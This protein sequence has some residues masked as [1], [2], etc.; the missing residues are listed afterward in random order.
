MHANQLESH[1]IPIERSL[2]GKVKGSYQQYI[3]FVA[4]KCKEKVGKQKE[5]R[6][7]PIIEDISALLHFLSKIFFMIKWT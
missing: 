2:I 1:T 6:L 5:D 7:K 4:K 3:Q